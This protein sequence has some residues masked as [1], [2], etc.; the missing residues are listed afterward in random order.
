MALK[1]MVNKYSR[2]T[3]P[4]KWNLGLTEPLV[5]TSLYCI[6]LRDF[7]EQYLATLP[8]KL[9]VIEMFMASQI[10]DI[11]VALTKTDAPS[12]KVTGWS[13]MSDSKTRANGTLVVLLSLNPPSSKPFENFFQT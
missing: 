9:I 2:I 13:M 1:N 11:E 10:D 5:W 8:T 12:C 7:E 3:L 4:H 6:L